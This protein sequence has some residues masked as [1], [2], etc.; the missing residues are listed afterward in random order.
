MSAEVETKDRLEGNYIAV[1]LGLAPLIKKILAKIRSAQGIAVEMHKPAGIGRDIRA[2]Q[3]R[4]VSAPGS[5]GEGGQQQSKHRF[6]RLGRNFIN[7][8][9]R[10]PPL[11]PP[12]ESGF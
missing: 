5:G 4:G 10:K 8:R 2:F 6:H 11:F 3:R 12:A 1:N 7:K 9:I